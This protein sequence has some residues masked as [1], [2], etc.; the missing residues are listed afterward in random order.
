MKKEDI[1][2]IEIKV[3]FDT[4][5]IVNVDSTLKDILF[6]INNNDKIS[7]IDNKGNVS[8][9][10][11]CFV[12][13]YNTIIYVILKKLRNEELVFF[14]FLLDDTLV[15][16]DDD[17]ITTIILKEYNELNSKKDNKV[18][19][20]FFIK[21]IKLTK[22]NELL[23]KTFNEYDTLATKIIKKCNETNNISIAKSLT[24]KRYYYK[25]EIKLMH[26]STNSFRK[27]KSEDEI[28]ILLKNT[29][30]YISILSKEIKKLQSFL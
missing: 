24:Y 19:G 15:Y 21:Q 14:K 30:N 7:L 27:D 25:N 17:K 18:F 23:E 4:F 16:C 22:A 12:T 20:D 2:N 8:S 11:Q 26:F 29:N 6:D 3:C 9:Y 28:D 5:R 13:F 10:K 1:N